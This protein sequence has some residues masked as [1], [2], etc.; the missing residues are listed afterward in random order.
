MWRNGPGIGL[1]FRR[2]TSG[3]FV[4]MLTWPLLV[5]CGG[6]G[7]VSKGSSNPRVQVVTTTPILADFARNVG[8]ERVEVRSIVP[9]GADIHSFQSTPG[10][11]IAINNA[12]V[13]VSNGL[14]INASLDSILK[15]AKRSDAVLVV[16]SEGLEA[17]SAENQQ[18]SRVHRDGD[19]HLWQNP[20]YA[21]QYV[22][23]IRIGLTEADPAGA[24]VYQDNADA[25]KQRLRELDQQI[26]LTLSSV[27]A[28]RRH[29][30]TF[31]DA[32]G[33]FADRYGWGVS[34]FVLGDASEV[35]PRTVDTVLDRIRREGIAVVFA[36]PQFSAPV[37]D[38][39]VEDAGVAIGLIYS[40]ILDATVPTY[41]E[42]MTFNAESLLRLNE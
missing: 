4:V 27:P 37:L 32:F 12:S 16:A 5:A 17:M 23:R 29:L 30:V 22:E 14:G 9:P 10:D 31:H 35:T 25:Y 41:I 36:E 13:I 42:M 39:V 19:P 20:L 21:V 33:H 28:Q 26:A 3:L 11:G 40:D 18:H 6:A 38:R 2:F 7:P 15:N 8:G 24:Q 34:A 1:N